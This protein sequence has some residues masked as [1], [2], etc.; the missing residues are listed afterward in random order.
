MG[1]GVGAM[2]FNEE[3]KVFLAQ[4]EAEAKN[5]CGYWE[6]PVGS[7]NRFETLEDALKREFREEYGIE[8]EVTELLSISDFILDQEKQHRIS[9]TYLAKHLSG[10]A[11]ILEP[12]KCKAIGW[13][14]INEVP[15][16]LSRLSEL[17]LEQYVSFLEMCEI[18]ASLR[19]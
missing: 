15:G 7:V 10:S 1:F 14:S 11:T 3:N 8:I 17:N 2:V 16:P 19:N 4:R 9:P 13:Y 12:Y 18:E 5:E 6:F